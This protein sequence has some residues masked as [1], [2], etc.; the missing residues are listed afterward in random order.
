MSEF[1]D[2]GIS[3]QLHWPRIRKL[4]T[5]GLIASALHDVGD[6]ILGW[7]VED[8]TLTGMMRM[9]SAFT[10]TS[11]GGLFAAAMLGM[12][13]ASAS[14]AAPMVPLTPIVPPMFSP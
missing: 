2:I 3:R 1:N 9:L 8:E 10:S 14:R 12:P 6:M 5:I 11:D 4:L 13:W 7:G